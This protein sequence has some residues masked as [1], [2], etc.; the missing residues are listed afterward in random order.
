MTDLKST[1]LEEGMS[2]I[3]QSLNRPNRPKLPGPPDKRTI[4]ERLDHI[5]QEVA[6]LDAHLAAL[7]NTIGG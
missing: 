1:T 3:A 2:E 6:E 7:R 5:R 4:V